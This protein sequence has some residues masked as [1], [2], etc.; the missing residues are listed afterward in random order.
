[1][2]IPPSSQTQIHNLSVDVMVNRLRQLAASAR[3]HAP[4]ATCDGCGQAFEPVRDAQRH[5]RPS[6]RHLAAD[7]RR[8][9][10]GVLFGE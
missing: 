10:A 1:M 7:R 4:M 3:I 2:K 9:P 6:C 5:C 8:R